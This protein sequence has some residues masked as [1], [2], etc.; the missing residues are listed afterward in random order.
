MTSAGMA[1]DCCLRSTAVSR[2]IGI[3]SVVR[4]VRTPAQKG[5]RYKTAASTGAFANAG[6]VKRKATR[7]NAYATKRAGRNA[8]KATSSAGGEACGCE[9]ST[10][11]QNPMVTS[12]QKM[13]IGFGLKRKKIREVMITL[14]ANAISRRSVQCI[15]GV[16]GRNLNDAG[17]PVGKPT[18]ESPL[19]SKGKKFA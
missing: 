1:P 5:P 8:P 4:L 6:K 11:C 16:E 13:T 10:T 15:K 17:K 12:D 19:A 2:S 3:L 14:K 9:K 18:D 7:Q